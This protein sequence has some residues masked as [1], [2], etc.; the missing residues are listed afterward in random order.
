VLVEK[1]R[2]LDAILGLERRQKA[3]ESLPQCLE[4]IAR[5]RDRR[6]ERPAEV[7]AANLGQQVIESARADSSVLRRSRRLIVRDGEPTL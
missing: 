1:A 7:T 3:I 5:E 2:S 6:T 4:R